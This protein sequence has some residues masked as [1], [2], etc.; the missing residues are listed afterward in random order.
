MSTVPSD[1]VAMCSYVFEDTCRFRGYQEGIIRAALAQR[2]ELLGRAG[3][4]Q[5][6][7]RHVHKMMFGFDI[8]TE[9]D[10]GK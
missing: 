9:I 2:G 7:W 10:F 3:P 8:R 5:S 6:C 1:A 4:P